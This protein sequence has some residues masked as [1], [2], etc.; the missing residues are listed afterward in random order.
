MFVIIINKMYYKELPEFYINERWWYLIVKYSYWKLKW[1]NSCAYT[2]GQI[3]IWYTA[4]LSSFPT[5]KEWRD[6]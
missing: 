4:D 1:G 5:Y 3:S 2:V 6:L